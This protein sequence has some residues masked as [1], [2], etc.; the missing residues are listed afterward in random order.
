VLANRSNLGVRS[1]KGA[2]VGFG[3]RD[4]I[5]LGALVQDLQDTI[6]NLIDTRSRRGLNAKLPPSSSFGLGAQEG[7]GH[8][9]ELQSIAAP[10]ARAT[11]ST[12]EAQNG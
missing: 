11:R 4:L 7:N 12:A 6:L 10:A 3:C 9:Q 5:D 1:V 8:G 2:L